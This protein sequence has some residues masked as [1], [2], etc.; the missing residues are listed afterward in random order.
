MDKK[1]N[2]I[3]GLDYRGL[4][5]FRI[6]LGL[7]I[8]FDLLRRWSDIGWFLTDNGFWPRQFISLIDQDYFL[9]LHMLDGSIIWIKFLFIIHIFL[10][11]FFLMGIKTRMVNLFLWIFQVSLISRNIHITS[12]YDEYVCCLLLISLFLPLDSCFTYKNEKYL[13]NKVYHSWTNLLFVFQVFAIHFLAGWIKNGDSW[14]SS[15]NALSIIFNNQQISNSIGYQLGQYK[16]F[17]YYLTPIVRWTELIIPF[18]LFIP[19]L[20]LLAVVIIFGIHLGIILTMNAYIFPFL[21]IITLIPFLPS[22]FFDL[23]FKN[24]V[25]G[26]SSFSFKLASF[27][28]I[29]VLALIILLNVQVVGNG[30]RPK[31]IFPKIIGQM[32]FKMVFHQGWFLFGPHP[33]KK[34]GY[35]VFEGQTD[36]G[37]KFELMGNDFLIK[38]EAV[39]Q[40]YLI[41]KNRRWSRFLLNPLVFNN[42]LVKHQM[43]RSF[44]HNLENKKLKTINLNFIDLTLDPNLQKTLSQKYPLYNGHCIF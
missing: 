35:F 11:L 25:E 34:D 19:R 16:N 28:K 10:A 24:K 40:A 5:L 6:G 36:A 31:E 44:C 43:V 26:R 29:I 42:Q 32:A 2:P 38:N 18:F 30:S 14:V 20:R 39:P 37:K 23:F 1:L 22:K 9:S 15:Q 8:I 41:Y 27:D 17:L 3:I 4:S 12:G 33:V 13:E 21:N 7:I